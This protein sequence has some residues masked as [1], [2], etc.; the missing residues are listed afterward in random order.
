MSVGHALEHAEHI[1]HSGHGHGAPERLSTYIGITMAVLGVLLAFCSALVGSER[2]LLVQKMI[3]QQN[4]HAKYQAQNT[5]HRMVFVA[6]LQ[7]HALGLSGA[8]PTLRKDDMLTLAN[9]FDRYLAEAEAGREWTESF[10]EMIKVHAEAQEAYEHGLLAA[11]IGIIFASIALLLKRRPVWLIS[12]VLGGLCIFLVA[13]TW[14]HAGHQA[15]EQAQ[16][17]AAK[18]KRYVEMRKKGNTDEADQKLVR[19]MAEWAKTQ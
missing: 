2:T 18:E 12:L 4:A 7:S 19:S 16:V 3:E 9:T 13:N 17:I 8:T 14:V 10:D 1:S 5:K 6:L 15:Q 11:E